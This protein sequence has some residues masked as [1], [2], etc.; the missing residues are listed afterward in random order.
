MT[1]LLEAFGKRYERILMSNPR[2]TNTRLATRMLRAI[3]INI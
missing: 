3:G 1:K 2:I